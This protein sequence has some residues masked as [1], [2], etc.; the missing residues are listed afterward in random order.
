MPQ[1]AETTIFRS[2]MPLS[3]IRGK[4]TS[5]NTVRVVCLCLGVF[6]LQGLAALAEP[7]ADKSSTESKAGKKSKA[8]KES[9]FVSLFDGKSFA[10]WE[11]NEKFFRIEDGAVVGGN[12]KTPIPRN[13]FLCTKKTYENFELRLE[14][15]LIGDG[16]NAGIQFRTK[17]IP[18]HHEVEGYQCDMGFMQDRSIWGSLYDESRRRKFMAHG[19]KEKVEKA[20]LD[21]QWNKFTIRCEGNRVQI[22]L[23]EVQTIDYREEEKGI[24]QSGVIAL[25][26]HGGPPSESWY[27]NI[28]IRQW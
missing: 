2:R 6:S 28:K 27:R 20:F 19:D 14:A 22:W 10:G 26:I 25:Q 17:R 5:P 15:K 16:A 8:G 12:L 4:L 18:D 23:N 24:S 21:G 7:P 9:D 13:E 3:S 1:N 11:G